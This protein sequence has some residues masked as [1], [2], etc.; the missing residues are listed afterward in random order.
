MNR[1]ELIEK[2]S[3]LYND[4]EILE[5]EIEFCNHTKDNNKQNKIKLYFIN[6]E[7]TLKKKIINKMIELDYLTKKYKEEIEGEK[8]EENN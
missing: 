3:T 1:K 6:K 2:I 4:I 7:K 8:N 5:N